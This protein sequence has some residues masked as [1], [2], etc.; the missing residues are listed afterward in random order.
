MSVAP[1][2]ASELLSRMNALRSTGDRDVR[3]L[4]HEIERVVDW[5]EHV[6][7]RPA[8]AAVTAAVVGFAVV[9]AGFAQRPQSPTATQTGP[10]QTGPQLA[11]STTSAAAKKSATSSALAFVGGMASTLA[12]QWISDYLKNELKA[13][14]HGFAK[15]PS[16]ER[17]SSIS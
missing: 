9:R 11:G 17:S 1:D 13:G 2:E 14:S 15:P 7:A 6:R 16:H 4:Q 5:R 3:Q 12:R 10:T 8:A